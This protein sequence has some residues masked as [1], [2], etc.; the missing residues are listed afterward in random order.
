VSYIDDLEE[1]PSGAGYASTSDGLDGYDA[2]KTNEPDDS[3][4]V[5]YDTWEELDEHCKRVVAQAKKM[6]AEWEAREQ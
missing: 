3:E 4:D 5:Y 6:R 2:W 1:M